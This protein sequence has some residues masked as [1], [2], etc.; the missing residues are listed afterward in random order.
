MSRRTVSRREFIGTAA[1][2]A[3]GLPAILRPSYPVL[4]AGQSP[5]YTPPESPRATLN[6]NLDW[7][8]IREDVQGGAQGLGL[9]GRPRRQDVRR[10][11]RDQPAPQERVRQV[12]VAAR[13]RLGRPVH[14]A[15]VARKNCF[16]PL[17]S[18]ARAA[19]IKGVAGGGPSPFP[20][21]LPL[22]S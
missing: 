20:G 10:V 6:F 22:L 4:A 2:A 15:V 19:E 13:E 17:P 14:R 5:H 16:G 21:P 3:V 8:F 11:L 9:R 18:E 7:K 1:F 12:R